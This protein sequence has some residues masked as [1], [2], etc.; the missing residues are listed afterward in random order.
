MAEMKR[1]EL[2]SSFNP[3]FNGSDS[4]RDRH[5]TSCKVRCGF[6]P[7]FNGSDS[8]RLCL[9]TAAICIRCFNPCFNGSDSKS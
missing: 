6:N 1:E 2:I 3:C 7:C 8:K 4:K 9:S 5:R